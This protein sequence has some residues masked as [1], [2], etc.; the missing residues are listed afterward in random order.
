M[1]LPRF[2]GG[3]KKRIFYSPLLIILLNILGILPF[4]GQSEVLFPPPGSYNDPIFLE[5]QGTN[6]DITGWFV[7]GNFYPFDFSVPIELTALPGE[8]RHYQIALESPDRGVIHPLGT[9]EYVIDRRA[10]RIQPFDPGPGV[11]STPLEVRIVAD[12]PADRLRIWV[13]GQQHNS[14]DLKLP[15]RAGQ[16]IRYAVRV[17]AEDSSGNTTAPIQGVYTL[18]RRQETVDTPIL[19]LLSPIE[20]RFLNPQLVYLRQSGLEGVFY[21]TDGTDPLIGG[22]RYHGP[23]ELSGESIRLR[24]AG[25]DTTGRVLTDTV[26]FSAGTQEYPEIAQG[27][28]NQTINLIPPFD[29]AT[30]T[31]EERSPGPFDANFD[32][33]LR[34]TPQANILRAF[35]LRIGRQTGERGEFRLFFLLEGRTPAIP[36]P[37]FMSG[38]D[39]TALGYKGTQNRLF[40]SDLLLL[41]GTGSGYRISGSNGSSNILK[42]PQSLGELAVFLGL[43]SLVGTGDSQTILVQQLNEGGNV[44]P[45][46][47]ITFSWPQSI[48]NDSELEVIQ[49]GERIEIRAPSQGIFYSID[50]GL[51]ARL[52]GASRL[53]VPRGLRREGTLRF[54]EVLEDGTP[55]RLINT[56]AFV[57]DSQLP[58]GPEIHVQGRRVTIESIYPVRYRILSSNPEAPGIIRDFTP[59]LGPFDLPPKVGTNVSYRVE[60]FSQVSESEQSSTSRTVDIFLNEVPASVPELLGLLNGGF[61]RSERVTTAIA[62]YDQG[63][64]YSYRIEVD[65]LTTTEGVLEENRLVLT[66]PQI[67]APAR[68]VVTAF[69]K[70]DTRSLDPSV[71][72]IDFTIDRIPPSAP[73]ILSPSQD[74]VANSFV[75]VVLDNPENEDAVILYNMGPEDPQ[76]YVYSGP[77]RIEGAQNETIT[78][79]LRARTE[80]RAGNRSD[81]VNRR[82]VIDRTPPGTPVVRVRNIDGQELSIPSQ[83]PLAVREDLEVVIDSPYP[84]Y[85]ETNSL[86]GNPAIPGLASPLYEGPIQIKANEGEIR[87][88]RLLARA[89]DDVGN[90][91]PLH[92]V[93]EI[94]VRK[95]LPDVP[96]APGISRDGN[97][98]LL[99]W[100]GG[101]SD[102]RFRILNQGDFR[103]YQG[104]FAWSIP[105]GTNELIFEYYAIDLAGNESPRSTVVIP[106]RNQTSRPIVEGLASSGPFLTM[107]SFSVQ[108][109][110]PQGQVRF[111]LSIEG[112]P[113]E[114]TVSSPLWNSDVHLEPAEGETLDYR[115]SFRQF[116][117]GFEASDSVELSFSVDKTPPLPPGSSQEFRSIH[118]SSVRFAFEVEEGS[119][120]YRV[121]EQEIEDMDPPSLI[122]TDEAVDRENIE[123]YRSAPEEFQIDG[124]PGKSIRYL[125]YGVG[126]DVAGNLSEKARVWEVV[127]DRQGVYVHPEGSD[128]ADGTKDN[129]LGSITRAFEVISEGERNRVYLVRGT[130]NLEHTFEVSKKVEFIGGFSSEWQQENLETLVVPSSRFNGTS[131]VSVRSTGDLALEHLYVTDPNTLVQA[132]LDVEGGR[133]T[134]TGG[135]TLASPGSLVLVRANKG[136]AVSL[137][138]SLFLS[139]EGSSES[140]FQVESNSELR[141]KDSEI[142]F[143]ETPAFLIASQ[144][145]PR[146]YTTVRVLN[147]SLFLENTKFQ[148]PR[149]R[150]A[151]NVYLVDSS[152][153]IRSSQI[154]VPRAQ[155]LGLGIHGIRSS[156]R[157]ISTEISGNR[158][159]ATTVLVRLDGGRL[160]VDGGQ[161]TP[162]GRLSAIG[163]IGQDGEITLANSEV[164]GGSA[165]DF[166][167][168]FQLSRSV[169]SISA[170]R[171]LASWKT[172]ELIFGSLESV[173]GNWA[174]NS[175][176]LTNTGSV[177]G[178][179]LIRGGNNEVIDNQLTGTREGTAVY[180]A[181]PDSLVTVQN[182]IFSTWQTLL[183]RNLPGSGSQIRGASVFTDIR[184]L[185]AGGEDGQIFSGN[186]VDQGL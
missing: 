176:N 160:S 45:P 66:V 139:Y 152:A 142:Q 148:A 53:S 32:R 3:Q 78:F 95:V 143:P 62:N 88:I 184:S 116:E 150:V 26:E 98:G 73:T 131:L 22:I 92:R 20:G 69:S 47:Q 181:D 29:R 39:E 60:A 82:I 186:R 168:V 158:I 8:E 11:Y 99:E 16:S 133:V 175:V 68:A 37:V 157:L 2:F 41:P 7:P 114:V 170:N 63:F 61:V 159:S 183:V 25:I 77:I 106:R 110:K 165:E 84:V 180:I 80:D 75:S 79:I 126:Q 138:D 163:F 19:E 178:F 171:V 74:L 144:A 93:I 90:F 177:L 105:A 6:N 86:G 127:I 94:Q 42:E 119:A 151:T 33:P 111:E 100:P 72:T 128:S 97:T 15:G 141:L 122:L 156:I 89:K 51:R 56:R 49:E 13:N 30:Y 24:V 54:W 1:T 179:Y 153:E 70:D 102:I 135:L 43:P 44:S 103:S 166:I 91:S 147:S 4:F 115:M 112:E 59:Y 134:S 34:I 145:V 130:Y 38:S 31:T 129:P 50:N 121:V 52:D 154:Q 107:P 173:T 101:T 136:A 155:D 64:E 83:G 124:V 172:R 167:T 149:A 162:E 28:V 5:P 120:L 87:T 132:L 57:I 10:P 27:F 96:P 146:N 23:F 58:P 18:D 185:E 35:S 14:S 169:A 12:D 108:T 48:T 137:E 65:G 104:P 21:S 123:L 182:N 117:D 55:G 17:E 85:I 125:I 118:Y 46:R 113:R 36:E 109:S 81:E 140:L 164:L 76:E 40:S 174:D 67:E 161:F 9:V 71:N